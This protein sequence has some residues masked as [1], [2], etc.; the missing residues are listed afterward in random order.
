MLELVGVMVV[1]AVLVV[2]GSALAPRRIGRILRLAGFAA[3]ALIPFALV[4]VIVSL[5]R[6]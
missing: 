4:A 5:V 1:S 2:T 3:A 6:D